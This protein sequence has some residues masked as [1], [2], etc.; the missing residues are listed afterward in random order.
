M[1][2]LCVS[3][4]CDRKEMYHIRGLDASYV[5]EKQLHF[6]C[7]ILQQR[8]MTTYSLETFFSGVKSGIGPEIFSK[9]ILLFP[10]QTTQK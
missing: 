8:E 4:S 7:F 6:L 1:Y 10:S 9:L 3:N 5:R 2:T